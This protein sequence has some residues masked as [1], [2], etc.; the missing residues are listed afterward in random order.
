[1]GASVWSNVQVAVQSALAAADTISAIT[2]A[3]PAV[4]TATAHGLANGDW[5]SLDVLGMHQLDKS[6][7]RVANVTANTFELE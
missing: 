5:V 1:M 2:K 6:V 4:V 7:C 3:N